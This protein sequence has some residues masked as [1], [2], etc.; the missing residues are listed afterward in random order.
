VNSVSSVAL[1]FSSVRRQ[2]LGFCST[3]TDVDAKLTGFVPFTKK[4]HS[5]MEK[6]KKKLFICSPLNIK[7]IGLC[8]QLYAFFPLVLTVGEK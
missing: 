4:P 1:C 6:A 3:A 8:V 2:A 7:A 5:I